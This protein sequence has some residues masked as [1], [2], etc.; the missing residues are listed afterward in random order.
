MEAIKIALTGDFCP[1]NRIEDLAREQNLGTVF[2][3]FIDVFQGNDL[4]V[5]DLECPLSLS[6]SARMKTG[7]HQKAHPDGIKLL[8]YAGIQLAAMANNHIMDY[9]SEGVRDTLKLLSTSGIQTVGI[10]KNLEEASKP[11]SVSLKGKRIAILNIA[12]NEFLTTPDESFVCNHIDPVR[13]FHSIKQTRLDHDYVIVIAHAGNEYYELPSPRTKLLYRA[14]IDAGADAVISHHTHAYSGYEVYQSKHI[15][16]GLGNFIYD[17]PGKMNEGWNMGYVVKLRIT[18]HTEFE[19][20]PLKQGNE[21]PG[22]FHLNSEEKEVFQ[23]DMM[24]LNGIIADDEQLELK[25]QEYCESVFQMYDAFLE[26]YF[27]KYITALRKRGMFP[28]LLSKRKRLLYLNLIRC[29][30]HREVLLR[31]LKQNS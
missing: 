20:I 21:K 14:M 16:Y 10:G 15:F 9:G 12:D 28:K 17:W 6:V 31:L 25:F 5:V 23:K 7:P 22:V 27:G 8:K 30:S 29:D 24:R 4:N 3:D 26:P 18:D 1:I 11:Y 19:V 13:C 2:H